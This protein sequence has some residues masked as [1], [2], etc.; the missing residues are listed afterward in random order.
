MSTGSEGGRQRF[1][2]L[3]CLYIRN[4]ERMGVTPRAIGEMLDMDE[5]RVQAALSGLLARTLITW[6]SEHAGYRVTPAGVRV[7]ESTLAH[8]PHTI[9]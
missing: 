9:P 2:V 8:R 1:E 7:I 4:A 6:Q 5:L 3:R